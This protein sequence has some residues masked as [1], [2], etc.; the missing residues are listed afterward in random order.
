MIYVRISLFRQLPL[1]LIDKVFYFI[2][3]E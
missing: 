3:L 1:K 2:L